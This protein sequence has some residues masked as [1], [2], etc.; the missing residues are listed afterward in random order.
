MQKNSLSSISTKFTT[1]NPAV[2]HV[3]CSKH[4]TEHNFAWQHILLLL[5]DTPSGTCILFTGLNS[6]LSIHFLKLSSY[7]HFCHV[8]EGST[9]H[10][11][12]GSPARNK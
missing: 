7:Q 11:T 10:F 1:S 9:L 2:Y 3:K 8:T 5:L 4:P 6:K 12:S